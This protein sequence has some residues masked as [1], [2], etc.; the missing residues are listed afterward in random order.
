MKNLMCVLFTVF[1]FALGFFLV[2]KQIGKKDEIYTG[3]DKVWV[4]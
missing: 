4:L 1:S 2:K 3:S